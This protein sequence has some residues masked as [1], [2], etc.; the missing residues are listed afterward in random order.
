MKS[1]HKSG[2]VYWGK[3]LLCYSPVVILLLFF[4]TRTG[5]DW[6]MYCFAEWTKAHVA[7]GFGHMYSSHTDYL[8]LYHYFLYFFGLMQESPGAI[9]ANIYK[10]KVLTIFFEFGSTLLL[11]SLLRRKF[12]DTWKAFAFSLFYLA[13]FAVLYNSLIWGQI[14]GI[15]AFFIFGAVVFAFE[16]RLFPALLMTLLALNLK[17][18]SIIFLPLIIALV[19][20]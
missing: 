1:T 16:K 4:K 12:R 3:I 13:N 15:M 7:N 17:L 5:H 14:D 18:H 2:P 10:M 19:I 11:F 9:E 6:D 20:P 8:P